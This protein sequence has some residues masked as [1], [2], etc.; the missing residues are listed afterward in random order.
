MRKEEW[1]VAWLLIV[2]VTA[3]AGCG[4]NANRADTAD[5]QDNDSISAAYADITDEA[6]RWADSVM[7][8]M[9]LEELSGQLFMPAVYSDD[10]PT[11]LRSIA[12]Y[13]SD[14]HVGGVVLLKG[15]V[16]AVRGIADTLRNLSK[17]PPFIAIDAEWG[18]AMRLKDTP[19][20][21]KN[22]EISQKA[23]ETLLFDYGVEVARECRGAGINMVLGPVLDVLPRGIRGELTAVIGNRSFGS[24]PQRVARL[25][26]AYARGLE[27]GNVMSVAKHFPGHGSADGDSHRLL[28]KVV[29]DRQALD[30][31]DLLPFKAYVDAGLGGVMTGHLLVPALDSGGTP[32]SVSDKIM[33]KILRD[34]WDFSGLIITDAMN[35]RGADGKT[36]ADAVM[37]GADL[38]LAPESTR[39][40]TDLLSDAVRSGRFSLESLRDRVRRVLFYKYI[41]ALGN[42]EGYAG[43]E[44][45]D[46]PR[47]QSELV[48][49]GI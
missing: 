40:E 35:M 22:G 29:K 26:T 24:D 45:D 47:L 14:C 38:V 42:M 46:S 34:E 49:V 28:P 10:S 18:L 43:T 25:G 21:P 6:F 7:A 3:L 30:S 37:A 15:T 44:E 19:R 32:A 20:F 8:G 36:G 11:A 1:R 9:T 13:A 4:N 16:D 41:Y 2:A 17:T 48:E 33:G 39:R 12:S 23:E 27:S 5:G 31:T